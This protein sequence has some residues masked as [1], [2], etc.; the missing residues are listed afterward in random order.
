MSRSHAIVWITGATQGIGAALARSVP[1]EH[2]RVINVS[3][4]QHPELETVVA[5]LSDPASWDVV[6]AHFASELSGFDGERAI[7]IHNANYPGRVGFAGEV[8][9]HEYRRQVLANA[10]ASLVLGDAFLRACDPGYDSGVVMVSSAAARHAMEGHAVYGAAKAGM[11]QWVRAVR[12]ERKRRGRGP[13]VIAV[14]PGFVAS[15]AVLDVRNASQEDYPGR[16]AVIAALD[17]GAYLTPQESARQIWALLPPDP[18]GRNVYFIGDFVAGAGVEAT[19]ASDSSG[20]S[21]R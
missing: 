21:V 12:A 10:A 13:W 2:A 6:A 5:D 18:D 15:E 19:G 20:R 4:R 14:R 17:A 11:E 3:R 7:F 9:V 8:D 16:D 1:Y